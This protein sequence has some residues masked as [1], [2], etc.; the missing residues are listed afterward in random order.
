MDKLSAPTELLHAFRQPL[1]LALGSLSLMAGCS[2]PKKPELAPV[3]GVVTWRGEP[4][5]GAEVMFMPAGGRPAAGTTDSEGR[6]RLSTVVKDDGALIGHH[7]ITISKRMPI[8]DKPYAPEQNEIPGHYATLATSGLEA[9]VV[10]P[11]PN[12]FEFP[13]VGDA[14]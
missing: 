8:N 14:R 13:L 6:F 7:K 12:E 1:L 5:A 9:D 2:G 3:T 10:A 11:G 4:V